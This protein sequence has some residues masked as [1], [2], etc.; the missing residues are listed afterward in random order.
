M[1][2]ESI[3][4]LLLLYPSNMESL[5]CIQLKGN[6]LGYSFYSGETLKLYVME[7]AL[8]SNDFSYTDARKLASSKCSQGF[9]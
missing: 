5:A 9:I 6:K 1:L 4:T 7:D 2:F 8:E 3:Y